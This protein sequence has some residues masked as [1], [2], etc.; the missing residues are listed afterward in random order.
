MYS[1]IFVGMVW[2][3]FGRRAGT[4]ARPWCGVDE[5]WICAVQVEC[6]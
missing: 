2:V 5:G 3:L 6:E 1:L 4:A